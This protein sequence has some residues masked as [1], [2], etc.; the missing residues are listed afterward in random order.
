MDD[1]G[2]IIMASKDFIVV[3]TQN[4]ARIIMGGGMGA[5]GQSDKVVSNPDLSAVRGIPPQYWKIVSGKVVPMSIPERASRDKQ[6][7]KASSGI[8]PILAEHFAKRQKWQVIQ[9]ALLAL[10]LSLLTF[11]LLRK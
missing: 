9:A 2:A 8:N 1:C 5:V 6:I 11:L 3:F 4:N 7:D 10:T